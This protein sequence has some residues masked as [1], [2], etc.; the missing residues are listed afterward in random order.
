MSRSLLKQVGSNP[1]VGEVLSHFT[2]LE[3]DDV[4]S[5]VGQV[6]STK[7]FSPDPSSEG[8]ST[9][10]RLK[11]GFVQ[12]RDKAETYCPSLFHNL[13][14]VQV[15]RHLVHPPHAAGGSDHR[16]GGCGAQ[17]PKVMVI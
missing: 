7:A 3:D 6:A 9:L 11:R 8:W 17:R 16:V 10:R 2:D 5:P 12:F 15:R 4:P 1:T 13:K 14:S